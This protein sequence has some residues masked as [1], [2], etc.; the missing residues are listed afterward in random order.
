MWTALAI[1]LFG[2]AAFCLVGGLVGSVLP[3]L[4]GPS[5]SAAGPVLVQFGAA[6]LGGT[7]GLFSWLLVGIGLAL[8]AIA[9]TAELMAPVVARK[10]GKTN[11]G[12][13]V[14]S[15]YG[16]LISGLLAGGVMGWSGAGS[17]VTAG[18]ALVGGA[19]LGAVL[20]VVGPF[21]GGFI[22]ELAGQP[23]LDADPSWQP[24]DGMLPLVRQAAVAGLAQCAGLLV[25]TGVKVG[26]GL[27]AI[28]LSVALGLLALL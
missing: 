24:I 4:P 5:V 15:Y 26:F 17:L 22:G 18:L 19:L 10:L 27:F 20:V 9:T 12:A 11:R 2:L 16:L 21:V 23:E 1:L 14:G 7:L 28:L 25:A 3:G 8:G 13:V 6:S